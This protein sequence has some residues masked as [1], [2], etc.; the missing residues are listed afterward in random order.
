MKLR[1]R[2]I[3]ACAAVAATTVIVPGVAQADTKTPIEHVVVIYSENISF[4]H[5]FG[6]YPN[7]ANLD[8]EKMQGSGNDAPKFTA[9]KDTPKVNNLENNLS[10][11]HI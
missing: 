6:T 1:H 3:A 11:I 4:D 8:G 10:L 7:A 2:A 9:K 5:Y